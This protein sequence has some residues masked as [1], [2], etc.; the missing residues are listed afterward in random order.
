MRTN[1]GREGS[2]IGGALLVVGSTTRVLTVQASSGLE[3]TW[4]FTGHAPPPC[5]RQRDFTL[6]LSSNLQ[7]KENFIE[8]DN[9]KAVLSDKS[10]GSAACGEGAGGLR[11]Q[12]ISL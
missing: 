9:Q 3:D 4:V 12:R 11:Y 8:V 5:V 7:E 1:P 6:K 2:A 10:V